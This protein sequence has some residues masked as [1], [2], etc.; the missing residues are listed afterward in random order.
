MSEPSVITEEEAE[1]LVD[2]FAHRHADGSVTVPKEA[3]EAWDR[4]ADRLERMAA[5]YFG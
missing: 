3:G 2:L 1:R 4:I 5:G